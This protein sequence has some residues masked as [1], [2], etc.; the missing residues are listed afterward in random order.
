M[1]DLSNASQV[2]ATSFH[3]TKVSAGSVIVDAEIL[4]QPSGRCPDPQAVALYLTAQSQDP[5]SP[6]RSGILTRHVTA[7]T[8]GNPSTPVPLY[9]QEQPLVT[10]SSSTLNPPQVQ[11]QRVGAHV[12]VHG[13]QHNIQFNNSSG[14]VMGSTD[15]G[16]FRVLLDD[17][18]GYELPVKPE[19][20]SVAPGPPDPRLYLSPTFLNGQQASSTSSVSSRPPAGMCYAVRHFLKFAPKFASSHEARCFF[21]QECTLVLAWRPTGLEATIAE[22]LLHC[23]P[24]RLFLSTAWDRSLSHAAPTLGILVMVKDECHK[25]MRIALP[26][27]FV[28]GQE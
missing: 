5:N 6:L 11:I 18:G 21:M 25:S 14:T 8:R 3:I 7:V 10:S 20:F 12:R 9:A 16:R 22:I 2:A 27:S 26:H 19:N 24:P 1:T 13:L 4:P 15:G 23:V 28:H 17:K